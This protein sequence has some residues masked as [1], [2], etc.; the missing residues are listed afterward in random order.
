MFL[1]SYREKIDFKKKCYKQKLWGCYG[2][3]PVAPLSSAPRPRFL[4]FACVRSPFAPRPLALRSA[5][6]VGSRQ[7]LRGIRSPPPFATLQAAPATLQA[8]GAS[9][10]LVS[11]SVRVSRPPPLRPR[12]LSAISLRSMAPRQRARGRV[13]ARPAAP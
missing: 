9:L 13:S 2:R 7:P 12:S 3:A 8:A 11:V 5:T 10:R 4:A 1:F 6:G